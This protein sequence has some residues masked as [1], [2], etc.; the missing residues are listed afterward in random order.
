MRHSQVRWPGAWEVARDQLRNAGFPPGTSGSS[1]FLSEAQFPGLFKMKAKSL[2]L[3][4]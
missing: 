1:P 2:Y 3:R 4:K